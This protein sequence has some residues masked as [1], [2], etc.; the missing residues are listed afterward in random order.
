[1]AAIYTDVCVLTGIVDTKEQDMVYRYTIVRMTI[2]R[3]IVVITMRIEVCT[4]VNEGMDE[5]C[6]D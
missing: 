1:M 3:R 4:G 6:N 5:I 2:I